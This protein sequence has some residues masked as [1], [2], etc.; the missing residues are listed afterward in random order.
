MVD[1]GRKMKKQAAQDDSSI[2]PVSKNLSGRLAK[3]LHRNSTI[4]MSTKTITKSITFGQDE[5]EDTFK[6]EKEIAK[7][8]KF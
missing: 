5:N 7:E 2:R 6:K 4:V 3:P 1:F 8:K